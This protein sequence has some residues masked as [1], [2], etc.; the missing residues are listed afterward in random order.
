MP[1]I[2]KITN[3]INGHAYIGQT[4]LTPEMR[5]K[6]HQQDANKQEFLKRPLYRAI[7]KYGVENFI[8]TT[9]EEVSEEQLNEREIYWINYYNTY[10]DGYNATLGGDGRRTLD[11]NFICKAYEELHSC[12]AIKEKY[13][14][15]PKCVSMILKTHD[16]EVKRGSR[17]NV[18]A[19]KQI[20]MYDLKGNY[21]QTFPSVT[22]AV[23]YCI[24]Q[25]WCNSPSASGGPRGHISAAANGKRKTAYQHIW[26]YIN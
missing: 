26:K 11:H 6:M 23:E 9:I 25:G 15:D 1:Y 12:K 16:I 20:N 7:Y 24:E 8:L 18:A 13:G 22:K 10:K 17:D 19:P 5:W 2:Y 21:L 3:K 4:T 14:Y